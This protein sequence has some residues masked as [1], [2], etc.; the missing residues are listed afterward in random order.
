MILEHHIG[1]Q[2]RS[3]AGTLRLPFLTE[4]RF[5]HNRRT[6]I[7]RPTLISKVAVKLSPSS[8]DAA[9]YSE[10]E[11]GGH[12]LCHIIKTGVLSKTTISG[13][14][15][16]K[17]GQTRKRN[18][19]L[20]EEAFE[21]FHQFSHVSHACYIAIVLASLRGPGDKASHSSSIVYT[22]KDIAS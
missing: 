10:D 13:K 5:T 8:T 16:S 19:R 11:R 3:R 4:P 20:T 12:S 7:R 17:P 14:D 1:M 6:T 15:G 18:F 2:P 22:M 21:Y 9:E